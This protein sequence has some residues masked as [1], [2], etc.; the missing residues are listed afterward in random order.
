[1]EYEFLKLKDLLEEE[2][3]NYNEK[4]NEYMVKIKSLNREI[5]DKDTQITK[6]QDQIKLKESEN[7]EIT[8][9]YDLEY[10]KV[11][12]DVKS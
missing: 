4:M 8:R 7:S 9:K 12:K 11:S 10:I 1:M 3:M 5:N 2:K 6:F